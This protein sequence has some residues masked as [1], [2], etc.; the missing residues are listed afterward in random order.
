MDAYEFL[1]SYRNGNYGQRVREQR[2]IFE[3]TKRINGIDAWKE[4]SEHSVSFFNALENIVPG[5][6]GNDDSIYGLPEELAREVQEECFF[7]G[8][9]AVRASSLPGM[10]R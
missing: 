6:L 1:D 4:F 7:S 10:G 2:T 8:W 9:F 5:T 3:N